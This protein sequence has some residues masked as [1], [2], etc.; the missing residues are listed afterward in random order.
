MK[1][2]VGQQFGNYHLTRLLGKGGFAEVS[3]AAHCLCDERSTRANMDGNCRKKDSH[4]RWSLQSSVGMGQLISLVPY[5][6]I[7]R[8]RGHEWNHTSL[9]GNLRKNNCDMSRAFCSYPRSHLV[10]RWKVYC[11]SEWR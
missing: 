4:L 1:D 11:L 3:W 8:I 5:W 6:R 7:H 2:L 10:T 9:D